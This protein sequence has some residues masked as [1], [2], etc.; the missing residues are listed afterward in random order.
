MNTLRRLLRSMLAPGQNGAGRLAL[1]R[2]MF[3]LF[4]LF[5]LSYSDISEVIGI[6]Y[7]SPPLL[8]EWF[9]QPSSLLIFLEPVMAVLLIL[10]AFG[11][12]TRLTSLLLFLCAAYWG[13]V[14]RSLMGDQMLPLMT[15]YVPLLGLL[16]PWGVLYS[17]DANRQ[18]EIPAPSDGHWQ[19]MWAIRIL[20]IIISILYF[21]AGVFKAA[22]PS[23]WLADPGFLE[24][25]LQIKSV[26][27]FLN[28]GTS[29]S[30]FSFMLGQS[31][32]L[33]TLGQY[34]ILFYE[35]SFPIVIISLFWRGIYF[36]MAY[37]FHLLNTILFG[38]PFIIIAP[39]YILLIDWQRLVDFS[40]FSLERFRRLPIKAW[41][42]VLFAV[43]VGLLWNTT[44]I[45]RAIFGLGGLLDGNRAF[46]VVL[47]PFVAWEAF[48]TLRLMVRRRQQRVATTA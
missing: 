19:Y 40:P 3:A 16:S 42:V 10:L 7:W 34:G 9:S 43:A 11:V 41:Q 23:G 2:I 8:F 26:E 17:V 48:M 31:G 28:N 29:V 4:F 30:P 15:F 22:H 12:Y 25:F 47:L 44:P 20:L 35:I 36:R 27:S 46:W 37:V 13:L 21:T 1:A 39:A 5:H 14:I 45:P 33:T 24:R 38:I 32:F 18:T 6:P